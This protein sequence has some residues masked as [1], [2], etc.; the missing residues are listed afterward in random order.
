MAQNTNYKKGRAK[1]YR[2]LRRLKE[3]GCN[4]VFRSAGSHS[5]VDCIGIDLKAR[6]IYLIQSKLNASES[7]KN[8]ISERF[9]RLNDE[10][11]VS[12]EVI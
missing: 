3:R 5:P 7:Q 2:I 4:I 8:R 1:E 6:R 12:F 10:F 11:I 9:E